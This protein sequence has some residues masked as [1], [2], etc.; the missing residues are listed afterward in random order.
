MIPVF[1]ASNARAWPAHERGEIAT[2][3]EACDAFARSWSTDAHFQACSL[4]SIPRR[5]CKNPRSPY[6]HGHS[7]AMMLFVVDVDD[8]VAHEHNSAR[9]KAPDPKPAKMHARE[10]W[11]IAEQS[12]I[13]L[14]FGRH[15][16]YCYRSAGGYRLV[17][18]LSQPIVIDSRDTD[19]AWKRRYL[20]GLAYLSAHFNI[21]GDAACSDWTRLF[22]LPRVK[23]DRVQQRWPEIGTPSELGAWMW[24]AFGEAERKAARERAEKDQQWAMFAKRLEAPAPAKKT[25]PRAPREITISEETKRALAQHAHLVEALAPAMRLYTGTREQHEIHVRLSGAFAQL[26]FPRVSV[27][28]FVRALCTATGDHE[29][30][31]RLSDWH[32]TYARVEENKL[33]SALPALTRDFANVADALKNAIALHKRAEE[34]RAE[35]DRRGI[36]EEISASDAVEEIRRVYREASKGIS[37]LRITEGTGKTRAVADVMQERSP[38]SLS[39]ARHDVAREVFA[40]AGDGGVPIVHRRGVLSVLQPNGSPACHFHEQAKQLASAGQ[41]IVT[42]LCLGIGAGSENTNEPCEH[43]ATCAAFREQRSERNTAEKQPANAFV[44]VHE[45]IDEAAAFAGTGLHVVDEDTELVQSITLEIDDLTHLAKNAV[46]F[47]RSERWDTLKQFASFLAASLQEQPAETTLRTLSERFA[48]TRC[49]PDTITDLTHKRITETSP[50]G[51]TYTF[52]ARSQF[53]PT[54]KRSTREA[55]LRK[56]SDAEEIVRASRTFDV[57]ARALAGALYDHCNP[58]AQPH[59]LRA[60]GW[61]RFDEKR[62]VPSLRLVLSTEALTKACARKGPTVFADATANADVLRSMLPD[63]SITV[64][65]LRVR[66]GAPITRTLLY[67]DR[68]SRKAW[69]PKDAGTQWDSGLVRYLTEA[70]RVADVPDHGLLGLITWKR[71]AC[72]IRDAHTAW[73]KERGEHPLAGLFA[74]LETRSITLEIGHYGALRGSDAWKACDSLVILGTPRPN[75]GAASAIADA[76][77]VDRDTFYRHA[78]AAE[79]SQ[80]CGRLRTPWREKRG[81][82]VVVAD[83]LPLSWDARAHVM[84]L[85]RGPSAIALVVDAVDL[86]QHERAVAAGVSTRTVRRRDAEKRSDYDVLSHR[87]SITNRETGTQ[88]AVLVRNVNTAEL[89]GKAPLRAVTAMQEAPHLQATIRG[90]CGSPLRAQFEYRCTAGG[91]WE[92][93]ALAATAAPWERREGEQPWVPIPPHVVPPEVLSRGAA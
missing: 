14:L 73:G 20:E 22:R 35:L 10:D 88:L 9:E 66:D 28:D 55:V 49:G 8:P 85:P 77:D 43:L 32:G 51:D 29:I 75:L 15:P 59:G 38:V 13:A 23:R 7:I 25:V 1:R 18:S 48:K 12:K 91:Q 82:I 46:R 6:E 45:C 42:T 37:L 79:L 71:L 30:A 5:L 76:I 65:D 31:K 63:T 89:R 78:I 3:T 60:Q 90:A 50:E 86:T 80:A 2:Y 27:P 93:R 34:I 47:K 61:I 64:R 39:T 87:T 24:P 69:I 53:A 58:E 57:L 70:I 72:E 16:G 81:H 68:S 83:T 11:W 44:S 26:G 21:D 74:E 36:A 52:R 62:S 56:R 40:L 92:T 41:N 67:C 54:M 17:W 33:V 4:P 84:E 19:E